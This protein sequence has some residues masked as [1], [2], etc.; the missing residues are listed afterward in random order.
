MFRRR[1]RATV[2]HVD[3]AFEAAEANARAAGRERAAALIRLYRAGEIDEAGIE[4]IAEQMLEDVA[5]EAVG[6]PKAM[7]K[8]IL[9]T[10]H[11]AIAADLATAGITIAE[12]R[13]KGI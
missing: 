6:V 7:L 8:Q 5:A 1:P 9:T 4:A 2:A 3:A 11:R 10:M 12:L 13:Q